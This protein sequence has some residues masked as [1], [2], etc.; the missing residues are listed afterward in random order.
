VLGE[1][2]ESFELFEDRLFDGVGE[3]ADDVGALEGVLVLEQAELHGVK[4]AS[5]A[6]TSIQQR[7]PVEEDVDLPVVLFDARL[8]PPG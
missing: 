8:S 5:H 1:G 2:G 7:G 3:P 4:G 6:V